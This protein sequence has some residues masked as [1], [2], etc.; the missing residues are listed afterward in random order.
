MS[1][2][3][4]APSSFLSPAAIRFLTLSIIVMSVLIII[5]IGALIWGFKTKLS[6]R[7]LE[8]PIRL[9]AHISLE[10]GE[11]ISGYKYSD[12]GVWL[13]IEDSA[14]I[15]RILHIDGNGAIRREVIVE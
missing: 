4:T 11:K 13:Q 9:E 2:Q 8:A 6:D 3:E 12:S 1:E 14:G 7:S 10:Q 15:R 5:G